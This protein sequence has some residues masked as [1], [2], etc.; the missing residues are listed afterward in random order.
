MVPSHGGGALKFGIVDIKTDVIDDIV[1]GIGEISRAVLRSPPRTPIVFESTRVTSEYV[2]DASK[3]PDVVGLLVLG[4]PRHGLQVH[5]PAQPND[6]LW[7]RFGNRLRGSFELG[8]MQANGN[9]H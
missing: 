3:C 1:A 9:V 5:L 8:V 4:E 6:R 7:L 2:D